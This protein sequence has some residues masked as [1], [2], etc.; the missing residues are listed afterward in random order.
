MSV[1]FTDWVVSNRATRQSRLD[2]QRL[3][4]IYYGDLA[5]DCDDG[6]QNGVG[7]SRALDYLETDRGVDAKRVAVSGRLR[8]ALRIDREKERPLDPHM[9][10]GLIAP[11]PAYVAGAR[12]AHPTGE[13]LSA[14]HADPVYRLPGADG[15]AAKEMPPV[16]QP[17]MSTIGY[18]I[19]AG[20]HDVTTYDW[21]QFLSFQLGS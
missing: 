5:P 17:V 3:A 2:R 14:L 4:A 7:L 19:R 15:L 6:F 18:H 16:H 9:L 10:L 12:G 1:L 8:H 13:S 11:R 21:E 20:K